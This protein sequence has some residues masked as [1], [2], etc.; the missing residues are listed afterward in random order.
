MTV[1]YEHPRRPVL[2]RAFRAT[3]DQTR[4]EHDARRAIK[5]GPLFGRAA[6]D[7]A[8]SHEITQRLLIRTQALAVVTIV[9]SAENSAA[10]GP[11]F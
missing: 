10:I 8:A 3:G 6:A 7:A 2:E 11:E 1:A 5:G 9:I 4:A